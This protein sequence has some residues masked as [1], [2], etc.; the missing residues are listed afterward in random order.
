[1]A[2]ELATAGW[3]TQA[4]IL[5]RLS[6]CEVLIMLRWYDVTTGLMHRTTPHSSNRQ[7]RVRS[8]L[9]Y[10]LLSLL[11]SVRAQPVTRGTQLML[12]MMMI[13]FCYVGC[14]FTGY[15]QADLRGSR[16]E[17]MTVS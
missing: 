3:V 14:T 1:M 15:I 17:Q 5:E 16:P 10:V 2:T 9:P 4:P 7:A 13:S 11:T 8:M 12:L 6:C